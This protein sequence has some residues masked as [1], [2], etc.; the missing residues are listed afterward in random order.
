MS[1]HQN[2]YPPNPYVTGGQYGDNIHNPIRPPGAGSYNQPNSLGVNQ[3]GSSH[4][5]V[6]TGQM[7]QMNIGI[8]CDC[9]INC[10]IDLIK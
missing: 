10:K 7:E 1:G 6:V 3:A 9:Y 8:N 5:P 2:I 4:A